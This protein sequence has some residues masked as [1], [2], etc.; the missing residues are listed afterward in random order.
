LSCTSNNNTPVELHDK[1]VGCQTLHAVYNSGK[2][3]F[4]C[5]VLSAIYW[6]VASWYLLGWSMLFCGCG[7]A[8]LGRKRFPHHLWGNAFNSDIRSLQDPDK[9]PEEDFEEWGADGHSPAGG[10]PIELDQI[11]QT[12]HQGNDFDPPDVQYD[13]P[14]V[15]SG[16]EPHGISVQQTTT[17]ST[18]C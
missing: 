10:A 11:H 5:D 6:M 15:A 12:P 14:E 9:P 8:I 13:G 3:A 2:S 1:I 4:C 17:T 16:F 7:A 18:T